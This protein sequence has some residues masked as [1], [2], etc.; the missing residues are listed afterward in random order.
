MRLI[1]VGAQKGA[2]LV[3]LMISVVIFAITIV[4]FID[5]ISQSRSMAKREELGFTAY[6][7]AKNKIE[8]LKSISFA[9]LSTA[10]ESLTVINNT[11]TPDPV[12]NYKRT[13]TVTTSYTG[14]SNLTQ[15][16]VQVYYLIRGAT[17]TSPLEMTTVIY[18][19]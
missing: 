5:V 19:G 17:N 11:G 10:A 16:T 7:L 14:D 2:T 3:E 6:N 12:G 8:T 1:G 4:A 18:N 15:I 9:D 13:T